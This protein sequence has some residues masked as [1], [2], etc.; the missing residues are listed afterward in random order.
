[1]YVSVVWTR[2]VCPKRPQ[3]RANVPRDEVSGC[4]EVPGVG[5]D[6]DG[7]CGAV[8][9]VEN[10]GLRS[11]HPAARL[12]LPVLYG[13]NRFADGL[14]DRLQFVLGIWW[15]DYL[16]VFSATGVLTVHPCSFGFLR[17]TST[18]RHRASYPWSGASRLLGRPSSAVKLVTS[19]L[20]PAPHCLLRVS[21][22]GRL[23]TTTPGLFLCARRGVNPLHQASRIEY[24]ALPFALNSVSHDDAF[25]AYALEHAG[26]D[27]TPSPGKLYLYPLPHPVVQRGHAH[28][29]PI[30][31]GT[32]ASYPRTPRPERGGSERGADSNSLP[33]LRLGHSH[34][35][36]LA[37]FP[38]FRRLPSGCL[39]SLQ[40][41]HSLSKSAQCGGGV[42]GLCQRVVIQG[43]AG[44]RLRGACPAEGSYMLL[45]NALE[46]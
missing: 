16:G 1:M 38:C 31:G 20:L 35:E 26:H 19:Y 34:H 18:F 14:E 9:K 22:C 39:A 29:P 12:D 37:C 21:I 36:G 40:R 6:L 33:A 32:V 46:S 27:V 28:A 24:G 30:V 13:H 7:E 25:V 44:P 4:G 45:V 10:H 42:C 41:G 17:T 3:V 11:V 5:A 8:A 15:A 43:I 2:A 23:P